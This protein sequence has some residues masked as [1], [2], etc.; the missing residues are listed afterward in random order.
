MFEFGKPHM[1]ASYRDT[2][3]SNFMALP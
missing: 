1:S 2:D 3:W